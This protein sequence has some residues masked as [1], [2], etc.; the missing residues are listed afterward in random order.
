MKRT[1]LTA[2]LLLLAAPAWAVAPVGRLAS[3]KGEVTVGG[4]AA[5]SGRELLAGDVIEIGSGKA[6]LLLGKESV[7][8]LDKNSRFQVASYGRGPDG[9]ESASLNLSYGRTRA[10][11]RDV[12]AV[13]K[14]F[15]VR[16]RS[17]T[18]GVRGTH[19]MIESPQDPLEPQ[20][21]VVFD[22]KADVYIARTAKARESMNREA[23]SGAAPEEAPEV[24]GA[25]AGVSVAADANLDDPGEFQKVEVSEGQAMDLKEG[26][27]P[28]RARAEALPPAVALKL[29][30]EIAAPPSMAAVIGDIK[31]L[32]D[33]GL[34]DGF[35]P[36]PMPFG[37]PHFDPVADGGTVLEVKFGTAIK[38][39]FDCAGGGC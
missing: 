21:F 29:S 9:T 4:V 8:H 7:I 5:K 23:M 38:A 19:L 36:P 14:R 35:A 37:G 13:R 22:G 39:G 12:G 24:G 34:D 16:S 6:T 32:A 11:V 27:D 3:A 30:A 33:G 25:T 17:A 31:E 2:L 10:L 15:V 26:G 28:T 20:R 1:T 18:M